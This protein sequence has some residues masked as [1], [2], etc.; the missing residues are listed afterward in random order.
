MNDNFQSIR[1][2]QTSADYADFA[3]RWH[4]NHGDKNTATQ[5]YRRKDRLITEVDHLWN[6]LFDDWS[7]EAKALIVQAKTR[8]RDLEKQIKSI[9]NT[10]DNSQNALQALA[11]LDQVLDLAKKVFP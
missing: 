7:T 5:F 3:A 8:N 6:Q 10:V 1:V 2:F 11:L 9:E 4:E